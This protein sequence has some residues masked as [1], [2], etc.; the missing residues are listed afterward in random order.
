M[1]DLS[2]DDT[3]ASFA[4]PALFHEPTREDRDVC[5]DLLRRVSRTFAL[6]IELLP[7]ELREAVCVAYL[8][9]RIVDT[10]EDDPDAPQDLR[11]VL[12]DAF[13]HLVRVQGGRSS[14]GD[15]VAPA[16]R[17]PGRDLPDA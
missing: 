1:L 10:I 14:A 11:E 17:H 16:A 9:C 12:F 15:L 7:T 2:V 6:S 4:P 5:S 3:A 13:D 8:L